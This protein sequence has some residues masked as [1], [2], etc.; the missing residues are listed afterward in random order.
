VFKSVSDLVSAIE[1]FIRV[2]NTNPKSFVWMKNVATILEKVA[3]YKAVTVT[4]H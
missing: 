1:E 2:N 4:L 3:R